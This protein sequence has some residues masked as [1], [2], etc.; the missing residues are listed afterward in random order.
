MEYLELPDPEGWRSNKAHGIS[1]RTAFLAEHIAPAN[2]A[3]ASTY[4]SKSQVKSLKIAFGS[5]ASGR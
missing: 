3:Q 5:N 2:Q 1:K 4:F